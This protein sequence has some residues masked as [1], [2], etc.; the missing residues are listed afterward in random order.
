[1]AGI[2]R[3]THVFAKRSATT[4]PEGANGRGEPTAVRFS[5]LP[6]LYEGAYDS[7]ATFGSPWPDL[8]RP[9]TS[10]NVALSPAGKA[11]MAGPSPTKGVRGCITRSINNRLPSTGQPWA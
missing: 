9:P 3:A 4:G 5:T 10:S 1:M 11:W 8:V 2:G 7:C 6:Q